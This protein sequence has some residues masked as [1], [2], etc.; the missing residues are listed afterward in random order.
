MPN[1][2]NGLPKEKDR[3]FYSN[4]QRLITITFDTAEMA[5]EFDE[6]NE[7]DLRDGIAYAISLHLERQA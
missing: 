5:M 6:I 4:R 1:P 2:K 3:S 7:A